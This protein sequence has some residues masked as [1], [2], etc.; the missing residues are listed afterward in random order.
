M[1]GVSAMM[2]IRQRRVWWLIAALAICIALLLLIAANAHSGHP[3]AWLALLPVFF[4]GLISPLS[5]LS[6]VAYAHLD[7]APEFPFRPS[8]F[9]RPPPIAL[10]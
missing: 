10:G 6:R 3:P 7:N 5:L 2:G 1:K 8:L 9:Q 4:V